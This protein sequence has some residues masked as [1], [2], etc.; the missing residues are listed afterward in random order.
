MKITRKMKKNKNVDDANDNDEKDIGKFGKQE[1]TEEFCLS[2]LFCDYSLI[3]EAKTR[4]EILQTMP[5]VL[6]ARGDRGAVWTFIPLL[7][8]I[9]IT[10]KKVTISSLLHTKKLSFES[11]PSE[12]ISNR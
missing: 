4:I 5:L 1:L 11:P 7:S 10:A 3:L 8:R 2:F 6:P 9:V 12:A